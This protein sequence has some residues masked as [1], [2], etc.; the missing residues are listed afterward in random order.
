MKKLIIIGILTLSL[1]VFFTACG[2]KVKTEPVEKPVVKEVVE[3]VVKAEK[4]ELTEEEIFAKKSLDEINSEG[5]LKEVYFDFDKYVVREDAKSVLQANSEWLIS[6]SSIGFVVE[7]NCDERGT[8]EYNIA[9]GEKR[10]S[11]VKKYLVS[12]GVPANRVKITSYGKSKP[13]VKGVD[14]ASHQKNRRA[15]FRIVKK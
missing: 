2:K 10:A 1:L 7:G 4:P 5:H 14:E 15:D 8:I 12:L 6:H 3:K 9:L 13:V 11:N